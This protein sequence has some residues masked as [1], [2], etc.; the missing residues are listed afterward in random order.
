MDASWIGNE[1]EMMQGAIDIPISRLIVAYILFLVIFILA[2]WKN[3][4]LGKD[5]IYSVVRMSLQLSLMGFLL[6]HIFQID[7]WFIITLIFL[8]M[9]FFA[10]QTI[11]RRSGIHFP[12]IYRLLYISILL[13]GG[14]VLVFFILFVVHNEP[15]YEPRYFIPLAGM[16][17]GNSM[18]GSALA[19]ERF[20]DDVKKRRR[21]IE[22][23]ISFGATSDEASRDSFRLAYRSALIPSLTSMTGMGIVFIPGMMTGQ[24]LGGSPPMIAIKYQMTIMAAILSA[25]ALTSYFILSLEYRYFFDKFHL[26][27][28]EIFR[29]SDME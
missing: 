23:L 10:A 2:R 1:R 6:T 15:W 20:Y 18:N 9:V 7:L 14:G 22:T 11:V 28:E 17:I 26:P 5:L 3:L 29:I 25:V 16:I 24:I 21:E 27:K 13:G 12:G 19:L 4:K 8:V